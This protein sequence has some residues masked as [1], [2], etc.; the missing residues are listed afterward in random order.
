VLDIFS[1]CLVAIGQ[2]DLVFIDFHK[3]VID[4]L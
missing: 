4:K 3:S 1:A 2:F